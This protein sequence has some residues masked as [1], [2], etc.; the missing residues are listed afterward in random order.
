MDTNTQKAKDHKY[1]LNKERSVRQ[2]LQAVMPTL[3]KE[4]FHHIYRDIENIMEHIVQYGRM[5]GELAAMKNYKKRG[6]E[7]K[8]D[9]FVGVPTDADITKLKNLSKR[10]QITLNNIV[11]SLA[12]NYKRVKE[13]PKP[14]NDVSNHAL[15][16][17][18]DYLRVMSKK[19]DKAVTISPKEM[20]KRGMDIPQNF[21]NSMMMN[22]H[23]SHCANF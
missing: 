17:V 23:L 11:G 16:L 9:Y 14:F 6:N 12:N 18:N 2:E 1:W 13:L 7:F 22:D 20:A 5:K 21:M 8:G 10:K 15:K 4:N 19:F 3:K